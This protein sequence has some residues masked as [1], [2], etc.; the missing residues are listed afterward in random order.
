MTM[1]YIL[2]IR[3]AACGNTIRKTFDHPPT[4]RDRIATACAEGWGLAMHDTTL[5]FVC[6]SQPCARHALTRKRTIRR[7]PIKSFRTRPG[8]P[9]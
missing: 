4:D 5:I 1:D 9:E 6:T 8:E 3:C 7:R 2:S